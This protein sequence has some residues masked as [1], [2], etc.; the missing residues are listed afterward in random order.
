MYQEL[1]AHFRHDEGSAQLYRATNEDDLQSL[2][3]VAAYQYT[4]HALRKRSQ[5]VTGFIEALPRQ[6]VHGS[7]KKIS[8]SAET[9]TYIKTYALSETSD[10]TLVVLF[11]E[12]PVV[13]T[14]YAILAKNEVGCK[15]IFRMWWQPQRAKN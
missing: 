13:K 5:S 7:W 12:V 14:L 3:K 8:A 11:R 10:H 4:S 1:Q 2:P 9:N 15:G 6:F